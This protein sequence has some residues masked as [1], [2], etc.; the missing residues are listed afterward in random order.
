MNE[1][2]VYGCMIGRASYHN[3]FEMRK[4]DSEVFGTNC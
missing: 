2:S 1:N 3:I 4:I